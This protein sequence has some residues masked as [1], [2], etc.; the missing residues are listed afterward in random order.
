[1][2][3]EY[4]HNTE[5]KHNSNNEQ[6]QY[7]YTT[8]SRRGMLQVKIIYIKLFILYLPMLLN[9]F[10]FNNKFSSTIQKLVLF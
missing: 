8:M 4:G 3:T 7:V 2:V 6:K 10:I 1:M 9:L 5:K